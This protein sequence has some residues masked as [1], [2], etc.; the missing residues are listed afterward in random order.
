MMHERCQHALDKSS[1]QK[2][3]LLTLS[4]RTL[5]LLITTI[6][7]RSSHLTL[8]VLTALNTAL[9]T[10]AVTPIASPVVKAVISY[11]G[12]VANIPW[13][14]FL[15]D[16]FSQRAILW[17]EDQTCYQ[18]RYAQA[19]AQPTRDVIKPGHI[20]TPLTPSSQLKFP[21]GS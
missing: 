4:V 9:V 16:E 14:F 13:A 19:A 3:P 1:P 11:T 15:R 18:Q 2:M 7:L 20:N 10:L 5:P 21:P 8:T 12:V 17:H 6:A